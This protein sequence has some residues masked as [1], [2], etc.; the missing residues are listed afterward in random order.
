MEGDKIMKSF[1]EWVKEHST[2]GLTEHLD[3]SKYDRHVDSWSITVDGKT[4]V[5]PSLDKLVN[6]YIRARF[7]DAIEQC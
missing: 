3:F 2:C 4:I 1:T 5:N 7:L 6:L